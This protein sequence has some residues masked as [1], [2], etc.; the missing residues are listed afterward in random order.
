MEAGLPM[1]EPIVYDRYNRYTRIYPGYIRD[2]SGVTG[3][4]H[5]STYGIVSFHALLFTIGVECEQ[6]SR[7]E[8]PLP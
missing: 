8:L 7:G 6:D 3:H 1:S 4:V 2:I 5:G